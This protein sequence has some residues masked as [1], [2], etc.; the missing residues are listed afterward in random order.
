VEV[1]DGLSGAG[2]DVEDGAVSV[3][4]VA[5]AGNVGSG[6]VA[7][8]D[9]FCVGGLRLFQSGKMFFGDDEDV[10]WGLRVDVFEGEDM[11]VLV[12]FFG[13]NFAAEDAAEEAVGGS[14]RHDLISL[15]RMARGG[16]GLGLAVRRVG[17]NA[18]GGARATRTLDT[19]VEADYED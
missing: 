11:V 15:Y 6:E 8:A 13:G 19:L 4:D 7:A 18:G 16:Q 10:S 1:E 2:A 17:R 9:D 3:L 14:V 5:L 12:N